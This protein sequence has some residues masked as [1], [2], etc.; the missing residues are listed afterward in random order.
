V[1]AG[2]NAVA[3]GSSATRPETAPAALPYSGNLRDRRYFADALAHGSGAQFVA[4]RLTRQP[5]I[6]FAHRV[7]HAGRSVGVAAVRQ[8][9]GALN[10]LLPPS[11]DFRVYVTDRH[12]VVVLANREAE[13]RRRLPTQDVPLP[14][15]WASVY[16]HAPQPLAWRLSPGRIGPRSVLR[17]EVD[18]T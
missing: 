16:V 7:E 2:G 10:R 17:A 13:L 12:G 3:N 6:V 8:D 15:D 5:G 14:S 11:G 1:D 18:G 4:G 9:I